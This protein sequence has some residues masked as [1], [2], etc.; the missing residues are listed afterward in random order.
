MQRTATYARG[1]RVLAANLNRAQDEAAGLKRATHATSLSLALAGRDGRYWSS[2]DAGVLHGAVAVIDDSRDWKSHRVR[3]TFVRLT[4]ADQRLHDT[5]AWKRNDP[6]QGIAVRS[7]DDGWTGTNTAAVVAAP[8]I[9]AS[10]FAIILDEL[11]PSA[12][13][14][15][16]YARSDDGA[17]CLFNDS[18]ATLHAELDV[19]PSGASASAVGSATVPSL[20]TGDADTT[21]ATWTTLATATLAQSSCVTFAASVSAI[22]DDGTE[23]GGWA[24]TARA[25]RPASGVPVVGT[26]VVTLAEHDGTGWGVRLVESAG[27]VLLQVQGEA[28]TNITWRAEMTAT[29]A[30]I[31]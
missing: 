9:G 19:E 16:L 17:L 18:G 24:F 15:F 31:S 2:P 29:E 27:D 8:V 26:P 13:R 28:A 7:F 22:R 11:A 4:A 25:R 30:R 23:G 14:V 6:T 21:D 1:S 20:I 5:A 10:V 3:G 12:S